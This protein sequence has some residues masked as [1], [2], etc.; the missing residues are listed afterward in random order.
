MDFIE[1]GVR[2]NVLDFLLKS[3]AIVYGFYRTWSPKKSSSI[4]AQSKAIVY[5]LYRRCNP[6]KSSSFSTQK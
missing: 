1:N 4:S 5:G 6:Q 3:K 2:R